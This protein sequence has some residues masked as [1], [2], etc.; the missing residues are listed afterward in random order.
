[1]WFLRYTNGIFSTNYYKNQVLTDNDYL[2]KATTNTGEGSAENEEAVYNGVKDLDSSIKFEN[3]VYVSNYY[4]EI[5]LIDEANR[6]NDITIPYKSKL[7]NKLIVADNNC[8][9]NKG[10]AFTINSYSSAFIKGMFSNKEE[11]N[12]NIIFK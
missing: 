4:N 2:V 11:F 5:M 9:F 8:L 6:Y 12:S 1:M 7:T 3:N 10:D